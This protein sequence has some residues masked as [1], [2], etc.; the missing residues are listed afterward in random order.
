MSFLARSQG[1]PGV[2]QMLQ[3]DS[4]NLRLNL[5]L[6]NEKK[7]RTSPWMDWHPH[8]S[9]LSLILDAWAH[10]ELW[11]CQEGGRMVSITQM[12]MDWHKI[13]PTSQSKFWILS[14][15]QSQ[16]ITGLPTHFCSNCWFLAIV[17][18]W[19][20][21]WQQMSKKKQETT[22]TY[23]N[24]NGAQKHHAG[25]LKP[26]FLKSIYYIKSPPLWSSE[27]GKTNS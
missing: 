8:K 7:W 12:A 4:Y 9:L 19:P 22:D 2:Y 1:F 6:Y 18:F 27:T 15:S 14:R 23:N 13:H 10:N 16:G 24:M 20:F 11:H 25:Q 5:I 26:D 21:L 17:S 3:V